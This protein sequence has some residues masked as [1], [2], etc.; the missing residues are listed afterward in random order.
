MRLENAAHHDTS[1]HSLVMS[2][3]ATVVL[4][5]ANKSLVVRH[6]ANR[7]CIGCRRRKVR[8]DVTRKGA[9]CT[10]CELDT[11]TC[12]VKNRATK[13]PL[14]AT[15]RMQHTFDSSSAP[16]ITNQCEPQ[17]FECGTAIEH[18][19]RLDEDVVQ[20]PASTDGNE[21]AAESSET[22]LSPAAGK[23]V[24][25]EIPPAPCFQDIQGFSPEVP[26]IASAVSLDEDNCNHGI[27]SHPMMLSYTTHSFLAMSNLSSLSTQDLSF[28]EAK[29]AL[30]VP[31]RLIL[32]EFVRHYFLHVHPMLPVIDEGAFWAA[33]RQDENAISAKKLPLLLFQAMIFASCSYV[34]R[35]VTKSLGYDGIRPARSAFYQKTKLLFDFATENVPM[36]IAQA[37][38]IMTLWC[39]AEP[40]PIQ[41]NSLWLQIAI[42]HARFVDAHLAWELPH[43]PDDGDFEQQHEIKMLKR[44]WWC[45]LVRDRFLSVALRRS[46]QITTARPPL[47]L[48]DFENE[49]NSSEVNDARTKRVLATVFTRV[50]HLCETLSP[51]LRQ[52]WSSDDRDGLE[53]LSASTLADCRAKLQQWLNQTKKDIQAANKGSGVRQH[54]VIIHTNQMY[55]FYYGCRSLI[56]RHTILLRCSRRQSPAL[57]LPS[58]SKLSKEVEEAV[59]GTVHCF[60][61][62]TRLDLTRYLQAS[63]MAFISIPLLLHIL[64]AKFF[65]YTSVISNQA[66]RNFRLQ[67]LTNAIK[68]YRTRYEGVEWLSFA[69]R[70]IINLAECQTF[71]IPQSSVSSWTDLLIRQPTCCLTLTTTIDISL[72]QVKLPMDRDL[73]YLLRGVLRPRLG[74]I[75]ELGSN[76]ISGNINA[77]EAGLDKGDD[78]GQAAGVSETV[79]LFETLASR[80]ED[81][82]QSQFSKDR[83]PEDILSFDSEQ[84][85]D[86]DTYSF[87]QDLDISIEEITQPDSGST[88]Y[89]GPDQMQH[90]AEPFDFLSYDDLGFTRTS[91]NL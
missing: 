85:M 31:T 84:L 4:G 26:T 13:R 52:L 2:G 81:T 15:Q 59:L 76:N 60:E 75:R 77:H 34:P 23:S 47:C 36:G 73:P 3:P 90:I 21:K 44:L 58:N 64:D 29:G 38:I 7:A 10:N 8:C 33:Y 17:S 42:Q 1:P 45:C 19:G 74:L 80:H 71:A 89:T 67:V 79:D 49:T 39:S 14:T 5:T 16:P 50:T 57:D 51:V 30:H 54:C 87:L 86:K 56:S 40:K 11:K 61:E 70:H 83:H 48:S 68:E 53:N 18:L 62:L 55:I 88:G 35:A 69:L 66:A 32:D 78:V 28:L 9:P 25:Q 12:I 46:T 91:F 20:A 43:N 22:A 24:D 37:A 65:T 82:S 72:S 6:R 63:A 27:N 41:T